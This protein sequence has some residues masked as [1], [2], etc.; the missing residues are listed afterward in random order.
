M[1]V[2]AQLAFAAAALFLVLAAASA[3]AD[4]PSLTVNDVTVTEGDSGAKNAVFTVALSASSA[5]PVTVDYAT[6]DGSAKAPDD[7]AAASGTLTFAPGE[8]S[9]QVTVAV[10]GDTLDEPHETYSVELANA[11]GAT[12]ADGRGAG[13]ILDN[14]PQVSI[15]VDDVAR[16]EANGPAA[17]TVSLSKASGKVV[18]VAYATADGS[19]LAEND[20]G[21]RSGTLVFL[22]GESS[23][24]VSV[25]LVDDDVAEGDETFT[26]TLSS[27]VNASLAD[28]QGVGTIV[29]DDADQTPPPPPPPDENPPP[30]PPDESP[31]PPPD[32]NPPPPPDESPP[33]DD[34]P[35]DGPPP[36]EEPPADP[37]NEAP[38]CSAAQPS[39]GRLWSPNHKLRLVT[40]GGVTDADGDEVSY[41]V[42][43]VTQDEPVG[44]GPDA[45]RGSAAN[46]IWLRAQRSGH[47]DGRVYRIEYVASDGHGN[48]CGGTAL[49]GVPHDWSHRWAVDSGGSYDSFAHES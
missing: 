35:S 30:P 1:S 9:K 28:A 5:D 37:P 7:Y 2:R 13:T 29:D 39:P 48:S 26:V 44:R 16:A 25:P 38:D 42:L 34:P 33:P 21:A 49:V 43:S 47:G 4:A 46:E 10:A 23:K 8:L 36:V 11:V 6:V 12:I 3:A 31:P 14:D 32:E 45:L 27:A 40:L 41:D 24:S 17:F 19:A 15:S 18:T 20:Y 22:A